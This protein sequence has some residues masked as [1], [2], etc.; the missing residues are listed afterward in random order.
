MLQQEEERLFTAV[1]LSKYEIL[2]ESN[3][4]FF[5][6]AACIV[7]VRHTRLVDHDANDMTNIVEHDHLSPHLHFSCPFRTR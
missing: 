7:N 1:N 5:S 2:N 6:Y 4:R 3:T